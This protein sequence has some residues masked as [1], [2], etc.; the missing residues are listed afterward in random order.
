MILRVVVEEFLK[1]FKEY[2]ESAVAPGQDVLLTHKK[3]E[4]AGEIVDKLIALLKPDRG[5]PIDY[6]DLM[7]LKKFLQS[8][9]GGLKCIREDSFKPAADLDGLVAA[10]I[11][12]IERTLTYWLFSIFSDAYRKSVLED[13]K[14]SKDERERKGSDSTSLPSPTTS[15]APPQKPAV[16]VKAATLDPKDPFVILEK[17]LIEFLIYVAIKEERARATVSAGTI[18]THVFWSGVSYVGAKFSAPPPSLQLLNSL[19]KFVFEEVLKEIEV[20]RENCEAIKVIEL[21]RGIFDQK[22]STEHHLLFITSKIVIILLKEKEACTKEGCLDTELKKL[23]EEAQ[24]QILSLASSRSISESLS[25]SIAHMSN[26]RELVL[27]DLD[28]QVSP[29]GE[30]IFELVYKPKDGV[31][32]E[33]KRAATSKSPVEPPVTAQA[34][35]VSKTN[36]QVT[37]TPI[38]AS[39]G[40]LSSKTVKQGD[41]KAA[42]KT[43]SGMESP[44]SVLASSDVEAMAVSGSPATASSKKPTP[45]KSTTT[46]DTE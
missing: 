42:D 45:G 13:S 43:T 12:I 14:E 30:D 11:K 5:K 35:D 21:A 7:E 1:M 32:P 38:S 2:R 25:N 27:K 29:D 19:H 22:K 41:A 37:M 39:G 3:K 20:V 26:G 33:T 9:L 28:V 18:L 44:S 23:V 24:R 10:S 46:S 36:G 17:H 4:Q 6:D 34:S 16:T 40:P 8:K 31:K 15:P